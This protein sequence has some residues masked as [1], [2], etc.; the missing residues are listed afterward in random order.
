MWSLLDIIGASALGGVVILLVISL[1]L[2][3]NSLSTEIILNNLS[4]SNTSVTTEIVKYDFY[5]IGYKVS[6]DKISLADSTEIKFFSDIDDNNT[7]DTVYYRFSS[8]NVDSGLTKNPNKRLLRK[9]NNNP[10]DTYALL[11][12]F[13]IS[14]YDSIGNLLS[15]S[16]LTSPI[17]RKKIRSIGLFMRHSAEA[18]INSVYQQTDWFTKIRPK[19]LR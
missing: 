12:Q 7:I 11:D 1:N 8:T 17:Q 19:N 4:Q 15:Y 9:E 6:G 10:S 13:K 5:K 3:M 16:N 14:Y 2:Q 18:A